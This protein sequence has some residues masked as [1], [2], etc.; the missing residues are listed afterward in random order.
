MRN[1]IIYLVLTGSLGTLELLSLLRSKLKK[2][3][4][5]VAALLACGMLLGI[6]VYMEVPVPSPFELLK[7]VYRPVSDWFFKSAQ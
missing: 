7:L 5:T 4:A 2:E 3:A 6:L 1:M